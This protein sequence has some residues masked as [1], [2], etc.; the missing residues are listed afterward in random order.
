MAGLEKKVRL[1]VVVVLIV[2][3]LPMPTL[4][5]AQENQELYWMVSVGERYNYQLHVQD[6]SGVIDDY[7]YLEVREIYDI[8]V[9]LDSGFDCLL[10]GGFVDCYFMNGSELPTNVY[11]LDPHSQT[12]GNR[13]ACIPFVFALG[14][15]SLVSEFFLSIS[16]NRHHEVVFLSSP[17]Y[18][19]YNLTGISPFT[20]RELFAEFHLEYERSTGVLSR[21]ST[22]V[23][24]VS[25]DSLYYEMS[26]ERE[27][28]THE[29]LTPVDI[30][31]LE[32]T[33]PDFQ[34]PLV[35]IMYGAAGISWAAVVIFIVYDFRKQ[36]DGSTR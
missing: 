13:V 18:W 24:Y 35:I 16:E 22:S 17:S 20:Y 2:V 31:D 4:I 1:L 19:G 26:L 10:H 29:V 9:P 12:N 23:T 14:N 21:Y 6:R 34:H 7:I 3:L 15:L 5:Q 27:N 25:N 32:Y 30:Q 36:R 28:Q 11:I 33:T 8:P